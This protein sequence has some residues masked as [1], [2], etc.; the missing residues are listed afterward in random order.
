MNYWFLIIGIVV[1]FIVITT[2]FFLVNGRKEATGQNYVNEEKSTPVIYIS[3][4]V[5]F[6]IVLFSIPFI[7]RDVPK[8][9]KTVEDAISNYTNSFSDLNP[10]KK[11][12]LNQGEN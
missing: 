6:L 8:N 5:V 7:D 11:E 3:G 2:L 4:F 1:F 10:F 9:D 12:P